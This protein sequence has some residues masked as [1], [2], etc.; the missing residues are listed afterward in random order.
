M[1]WL[2]YSTSGLTYNLME[3]FWQLGYLLTYKEPLIRNTK[4]QA[5]IERFL[6]MP[7]KNMYITNLI[8]IILKI[9]ILQTI[10]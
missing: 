3:H 5:Q 10:I 4:S 6:N 8:V 1:G 7:F 9:Q 2:V